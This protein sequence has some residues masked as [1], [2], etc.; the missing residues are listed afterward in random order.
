MMG[1][2]TQHS[3]GKRR[4]AVGGEQSGIR[5]YVSVARYVLVSVVAWPCARYLQQQILPF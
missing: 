4:W 2:S 1:R 5:D 3:Y